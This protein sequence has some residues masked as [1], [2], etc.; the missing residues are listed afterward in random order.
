MD[1]VSP[2]VLP[3]AY[4]FPHIYFAPSLQDQRQALANG[5]VSGEISHGHRS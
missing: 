2:V 3:A 1:S 4:I 5:A